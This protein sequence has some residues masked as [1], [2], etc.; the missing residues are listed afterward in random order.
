MNPELQAMFVADAAQAIARRRDSS[1]QA[2]ANQRDGASYDMR[3]LGAF[4]TGSLF[5]SDDAER[6]AGLN[7]GA[8]IPVTLDQPGAKIGA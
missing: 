4:M 1:D 7:T 3:M 6:F 8:R 2:M 5:A